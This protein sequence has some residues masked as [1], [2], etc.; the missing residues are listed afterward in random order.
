MAVQLG[1]KGLSG[2]NNPMGLLDDCHRRIEQFLQTLIRVAEDKRGGELKGDYLQGL[3]TSLKYFKEA[4]PHHTEDEED[5]VF[6]RLRELGDRDERIRAAFET[7]DALEADHEKAAAAHDEI[8]RLGRKWLDEGFLLADEVD[9]LIQV[10]RELEATYQRHIAVEDQEIF[11]LAAEVLPPD[12]LK[13]IGREM[14][15]RRGVPDRI[16]GVNED[17]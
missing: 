5:S 2:F 3:K 17:D 15:D 6:P 11:P 10:L 7:I 1:S 13:R 16:R 12:E 4:A 8:D 14:A 9:W